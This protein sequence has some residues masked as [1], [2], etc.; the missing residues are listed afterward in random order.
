MRLVLV[1]SGILAA[2]AA[3]GEAPRGTLLSTLTGRVDDAAAADRDDD[4]FAD[5]GRRA[6]PITMFPD[7]TRIVF[8]VTLAKPLEAFSN[9]IAIWHNL[10]DNDLTRMLWFAAKGNLW[11]LKAATIL[12]CRR[13][14][15]L[16][17]IISACGVACSPRLTISA[18]SR[19]M[20]D[21]FRMKAY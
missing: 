16:S 2:V 21:F 12:T 4:E 6:S 15:K 19:T 18:S 5:A 13:Y 8:N 7:G 1:F 20:L 17:I 11:T 9:V 3:A 10:S 14:P